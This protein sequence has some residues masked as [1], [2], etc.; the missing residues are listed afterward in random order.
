MRRLPLRSVVASA[1]TALLVAAILTHSQRT[2]GK[3]HR[4]LELSVL[5]AWLAPAALIATNLTLALVTGDLPR[6]A[7]PLDTSLGWV[8]PLTLAAFAAP[9]VL[10]LV[11]LLRFR[12][13][14]PGTLLGVVVTYPIAFYLDGAG[15]LL[16]CVDALMDRRR[17]RKVARDRAAGA[18]QM[19]TPVGL[20]ESWQLGGG[21]RLAGARSP[22]RLGMVLAG[23]AALSFAAGIFAWPERVVAADDVRCAPREW[24]DL[25]WVDGAARSECG[26][27]VA[28]RSGT[29][30]PLRVDDFAGP[31]DESFWVRGDATFDCNESYF[32]PANVR[33]GPAGLVLDLRP[34]TRGDRRFTTGSVSTGEREFLH[35]RFE[36]AM[37]ASPASGVVSAFFLYRFDP[38]QEIDFELLGNDTTKALVNVYFNPGEDGDLYNYGHFGTPVE[39][40]LGFDAATGVHRYAIE[41]DAEEIRWFADDRL[42]HVRRAGEPTPIPHLPMVFHMNTWATCSEALAGPI[43]EAALPTH[44]TFQSVAIHRW[45]PAPRSGLDALF[46]DPVDPDGW[47]T[48][49]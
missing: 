2:L 32:T 12:Q 47:M 39:V 40:D 26:P 22:S 17:W 28:L 44:A 10:L 6:A 7:L 49:D 45:D 31:L 14:G 9:L 23:A 33:T 46:H 24:D 8:Q 13:W 27:R 34:E 36:V 16:G 15:A 11:G 25:P 4:F 30:T 20:R 43:D 35:G 1:V 38:W 3:R 42:I 19:P 37:Q 48:G 29:A 5:F 21:L 18:E 41:W